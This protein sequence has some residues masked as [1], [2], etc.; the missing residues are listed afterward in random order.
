MRKVIVAVYVSLDGVMQSPGAPEEDATGGFE[1]GG[2]MVP[3][4]DDELAGFMDEAMG[5]D[6][7][8]LLGRRSYEMLAAVWPSAKGDLARK[9]NAAGKYVVAGPETELTWSGSHRLEGDV[10]EAVAELK[11]GKGP[12]L[13]IFGSRKLIQALL[14]HDLI[15]EITLL[16]IPVVLGSGKRLF[17]VGDPAG[18]WAL[19]KTRH[20]SKGVVAS[21]YRRA[22]DLHT[23]AAYQEP[24]KAE[25]A[26]RKRLAA[27]DQPS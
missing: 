4:A 6:Y 11:Q 25:L 8:L 9:L 7:D 2:W 12:P 23:G 5:Q 20:S 14:P 21:T 10:I 3:F 17:D 18:A 27:E 15:D 19:A 1:L 26:R 24:S 13:I 22:G 16:V